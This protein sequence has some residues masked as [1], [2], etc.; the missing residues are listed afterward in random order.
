[1]TAQEAIA[2]PRKTSFLLKTDGAETVQNRTNLYS[3]HP[4]P[5]AWLV[6]LIQAARLLA[7]MV[8]GMQLVDLACV[9]AKQVA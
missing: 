2:Y 4:V 9:H 8:H 7:I 6:M 5:V 3:T 1:M